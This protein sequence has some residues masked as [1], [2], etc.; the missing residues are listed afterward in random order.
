[1]YV[2][3]GAACIIL[4]IVLCRFEEMHLFLVNL[5]I[6][7]HESC[8]D[9]DSQINV[10]YISRWCHFGTDKYTCF[11]FVRIFVFPLQTIKQNALSS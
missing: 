9:H 5:H 4:R 10:M 7:E 2:Y 11:G 3:S 8:K 1:M 6:K